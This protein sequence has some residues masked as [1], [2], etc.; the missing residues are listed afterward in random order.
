MS[1]I[2]PV[3]DDVHAWITLRLHS[4][5]AMSVSGNIGDTRLAISMLDGARDAVKR[6]VKR[7]QQTIVTPAYDVVAPQHEAFPTRECA[8]L[9]PSERGDP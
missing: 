2:P 5:G 1:D 3:Q 4:N 8:H 9:P 7:A 6:Q